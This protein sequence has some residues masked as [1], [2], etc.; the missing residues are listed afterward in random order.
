[1]VKKKHFIAM[2]GL[3]MVLFC[4]GTIYAMTS[5]DV[6]NH[7]ETGI[8]DINLSEHQKKGEAEGVWEDNPI[9]LPGDEISKIPRITNDGNDCYVRAKITFRETDE[10]SES[11][12]FG[13]GEHWLKADDG[14]YYFTKILPHGESVDIFQGVKI[15]GDFSQENEEISFHI[16]IDADA[17]QSKNFTPKF[18]SATPWGNVEILVCKKEGQYDVS[19]FK[20]S[21]KQSF[22]IKYEGDSKK[23][24]K[25]A[26]DFFANMPYL[27]PGDKYHDTVEITNTENKDIKLYFRSEA[28]DDSE[29]L[30][31]ILLK[32][33]TT[34]DGEKKVLYTGNLKASQLS[35]DIVL[36]TL[37]KNSKGN[38]DFEI[39]VPAEL[40]NKYSIQSSHVKWVFSTEP[41]ESIEPTK[42]ESTSNK[43]QTGDSANIGLYISLLGVS[44]A[45]FSVAGLK[46]LKEREGEESE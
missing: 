37:P 21:D 20:K 41:I 15:P 28:T 14:Y 46:R 23:L 30:E 8:V 11:D 44:L 1:M 18:D 6:T 5:V 38:F 24:I 34:I 45:I 40:N 32:I 4:S 31:K 17:I 25:N 10:I 42:N 13:F 36:G 9:V 39:E 33:T 12:L 2:L 43:V 27:M 16:D 19:T 35:K 3:S 7:F 22:Q 29:L 26:D